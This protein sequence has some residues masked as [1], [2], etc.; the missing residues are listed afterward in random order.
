M[1]E[2]FKRDI[3]S[4]IFGVDSFW[5]GVDVPGE[6]LS[7]V[8]ITRLPFSV[9]DHPIA[10]ARMEKIKENGG[11]PF[12]EYSLPQAILKL[13]QGFGRLIRTKYDTGTV[14]ILDSR[15]LHKPYGRKFLSALP[16]CEIIIE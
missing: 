14:Y 7:N 3:G 16:E 8:V 13:K 5:T 15:I 2:T 6:A 9:P 10:E 4:V 12:H 11:D 1:L